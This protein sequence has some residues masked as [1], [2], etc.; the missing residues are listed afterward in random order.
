MKKL[1]QIQKSDLKNITRVFRQAK[2][3]FISGLLLFAQAIWAPKQWTSKWATEWKQKIYFDDCKVCKMKL[4]DIV[5]EYQRTYPI[6][7][8]KCSVQSG[9]HRNS[10]SRQFTA[11]Q[12]KYFPTD[13]LLIWPF[14]T[15]TVLRLPEIVRWKKIVQKWNCN[16]Q[17]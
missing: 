3:L 9:D 1:L 5:K 14:A 16:R 7:L 11:F 17:C 6:C 13:S 10:Q 2:Q 12:I 4:I 8:G 15:F